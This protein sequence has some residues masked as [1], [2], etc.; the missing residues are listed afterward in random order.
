MATVTVNINA[1][2]RKIQY[3]LGLIS[4]IAKNDKNVEI[5]GLEESP[6]N[7][8][9]VQELLKSRASKGKLIKTEDLWK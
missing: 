6:Y 3:L 2:T 9:F 4:E 8:E 7:P 1:R 5:I